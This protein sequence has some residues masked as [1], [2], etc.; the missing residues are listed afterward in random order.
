M[1]RPANGAF[2]GTAIPEPAEE[3]TGSIESKDC[4][5]LN[6]GMELEEEEK[7]E[8]PIPR[9]SLEHPLLSMTGTLPN[10]VPPP[11]SPPTIFAGVQS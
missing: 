5:P 11:V 6:E 3:A 2:W 9:K 4:K 7:E 10:P 1:V 8:N